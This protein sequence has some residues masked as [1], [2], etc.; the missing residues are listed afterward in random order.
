MGFFRNTRR[1]AKK[2]QNKRTG[3]NT[4]VLESLEPRILLDAVTAH[5]VGGSGDWSDPTHWDIGYVPNDGGGN[6]YIAVITDNSTNVVVDVTNNIK[7]SGLQNCE[8][9]K[10]N[11]GGALTASGTVI[12]TGDIG[13][14]GGTLTLSGATVTNTGHAIN[15]NTGTVQINNTT[16]NGG[17]VQCN[18]EGVATIGGVSTLSGITLNSD[19]TITDGNSLI[20]TGGLILNN[21]LTLLGTSSYSHLYLQDTQTISGTGQIVFDGSGQ[22]AIV[23]Q[24][25]TTTVGHDILVQDLYGGKIYGTENMQTTFVNEGK[26]S[27]ATGAILQIDTISLIIEAEGKISADHGSTVFILDAS[28]TIQDNGDMIAEY[29]STISVYNSTCNIQNSG[30]MLS[31]YGCEFSASSSSFIINGELSVRFGSTLFISDSS[32]DIKNGVIEAG[33]SSILS[34]SDSIFTFEDQGL[35]WVEYGSAFSISNSLFTIEDEGLI[36][37]ESDSVFSISDSTFKIHDDGYIWVES[38]SAFSISNSSFT[39]QAHD[40]FIWVESD[41]TFSILNSSFKFQDWGWMWVESGSTLSLFNSSIIVQDDCEVFIMDENW[42][43]VESGPTLSLSNSSFILKDRGHLFID[44]IDIGDYSDPIGLSTF[45]TGPASIVYLKGNILGSTRNADQYA[46]LGTVY[47]EGSGT[48]ASPQL[49]EVMGQDLGAETA[50][51]THNFVF[52]TL[53]LKQNTYV[54]LVD[55]SNNARGIGN[56]ALYVDSLVVPSGTTLDLNGLH[57]YVRVAQVSGTIV[58]AMSQIADGGPLTLGTTT[59]GAISVAGDLDEWTFYGRAGHSITT[60]V[61]TASLS[62]NLAYAQIDLVDASDNIVASANSNTDNQMVG[63]YDVTLPTDGTYRIRISAPET[64]IS[65]TGAYTVTAWDVT[66]DVAS[67]SLNQQHI[68]TIETPYSVDRW[69]FSA[70]T[71]D[72]LA[73]DFINASSSYI[74]FDL[75]GPNGWIGFNDIARDS[76]LINLPASGTYILTVHSVDGMSNIDYAFRLIESTQTDLTPNSTYSGTFAGSGQTQLFKVTIPETIPMRVVLDDSSSLDYNQVYVRYGSPPTLADYDFRGDALASADQDVLVPLAKPGTWYILVYGDNVPTESNYDLTVKT[77]HL[78]VTGIT[79][80]KGISNYLNTITLMGAGFNIPTD[81][82][83]VAIDGTVYALSSVT[84]DSFTTLTVTFD[85]D[86]VPIG[87]YSVRASQADGDVVQLD[88]TFSMV[89]GQ[90]HLETN[91]IVPGTLGR[92]ATAT[93]YIEYANTGDAPM[94]APLLVLASA[95][96]ADKPILTLDSSNLI[97]NLWTSAIPEGCSTSIQI[98]ASGKTPGVLQPGE[99]VRVPVYYSGLLLPWTWN[100]T[101]PFNLGVL[102]ADDTTPVD[103]STLK[104]SMKPSSMTTDAWNALFAGFTTD[105]GSTW[106]DYIKMLDDNA[107][108]LGQLGESVNDISQLLSFEFLQADGIGPVQTLAGAVDAAVDAPGMPIVFSRFFDNSVS[109]KYDLGRLGYGWDDNWNYFLSVRSDGTVDIMGPGGSMRIFQPDGR[110]S[111]RYF[112][113]AGDY[114]TLSPINGGGYTLK[115]TD[116]TVYA[117]GS[118]GTLNH[119]EDTNHNRI[120]C[121]YAGSLLTTLTHS[122]GQSLSIVYDAGRI[123]NM[124]DSVDRMTTYTYD[125]AGQLTSVQDYDGKI[126]SYTYNAGHSLTSVAAPGGTHGYFTYGTDGRLS[127]TSLDNGLLPTTFDYD[128]GKVI[129]TDGAGNSSSFYYDYRGLLL[130]TENALGSSVYSTYDNSYNLTSLTDATGRSS[131]YTYDA[132]GNVTKAVDA[133]GHSTLFTYTSTYNELA[134]LTDANGNKTT[135][136]YDGNGNL[137]S[138]AYADRTV[139]KNTYNSLGEATS[140]INRRGQT[141]SYTYETSGRI[142][143]ELFPDGTHNDYVYNAHGNLVTC[144]DPTGTTTFTYDPVTDYLTR[145]HYSG[146]KYLIFTYD[147]AGRRTSSTDELGHIQTYHYDIIGRLESVTDENTDQIAGY[148]YD[149]AGRLTRKDLGNGVYTA[150]DYDGAGQLLHLINCQPDGTV[151]S[152]FDYTYDSRGLMTSMATVDGSWAYTY[153]DIG[154]LTHAVFTS[155]NPLVQNQDLAYSYDAMGNRIQTVEN[156]VVTAY[157][158]NNMNQ[159]TQVGDITYFY[160]ADGNLIREVS[161]EGITTYTYNTQNQLIAITSP[162]GNWQ[163]NYNALGNRVSSTE[164]G[165]TTTYVTDPAGFGNVVNIYNTSGNPLT[166]YIYTDG[167]LSQITGAT[168]AYYTYGNVG[169]TSELTLDG[170]IVA[171]SYTYDP[172]GKVLSS[173]ATL[174]NP[175]QFVGQM[176]VMTDGG[177]LNYMRARY[178]DAE[179][180]RFMA[181][182]PIGIAGGANL[183]GYV[184][185][186]PTDGVDPVGLWGPSGHWDLTKCAAV[187]LF[188][189]AE[190]AAIASANVRTDPAYLLWSDSRHY[191]PGTKEDAEAHKRNQMN[192]AVELER[193]GLHVEALTA[194][195]VGLHTTQDYYAHYAQNATWSLWKGHGPADP[196]NPK[197][198]PEEYAQALKETAKYLNDFLERTGRNRQQGT[199]AVATAVDPNS[200]LGPAGYGADGHIIANTTLAYQINFENE[201]FATAPAQRVTITNQLDTDLGWNTFELTDIGFGDQLITV[202]EHTSHFETT[203]SMTYNNKTFDVMIEAGIDYA[204]GQVY[205]VFQSVDPTTS[206]PPDVLIGFLPPEDGTGRGMGHISY[207]IDP[208]AGL[209]TGTQIR[210]IAFI[211]FDGQPQI[212]TN[213]IN[214]HDPSQGTDPAKEAL[215]TIDASV[216]ESAVLALPSST[217]TTDFLVQWTGS[218]QGSGIAEYDVYVSTDGSSYTLWKATP[219]TSAIFTGVYG[220]TYS[221]YSV[222]KDNVGYVELAPTS[223][224]ATTTLL[225]PYTVPVV[226]AGVDLSTPEGIPATVIASFADAGPET[227]FS[228]LI[229][230]GD[231]I[232]SSGTLSVTP[233]TTG[234]SGNVTGTHLYQAPGSYSVLVRVTDQQGDSAT[235]TTNITVINLSPMV[236]AGTDQTVNEGQSVT[237]TGT[238]TDPGQLLGET[239]TAGWQ[240]YDSN[241][242]VVASGSSS[243][244]TFTP[245][246]GN[247]TAVFTVTDS[248]GASSSDIMIMTVL[249][250]VPTVEAGVDQTIN[251][252]Q[253]VTLTGIFTDPGQFLGETYTTS[254]LILDH[255]NQT[256]ASG[257]GTTFT[258]TPTAGTYTTIFTVTDSFGASSSDSAQIT[259]ISISHPVITSL[260]NSSTHVGDAREGQV[261]TLS[262]IFTDSVLGHTA[263]IDWGDGTM[264]SGT[265]TES[266]HT[267]SGTHTYSHGGIYTIGVVLS[268]GTAVSAASTV[269]YITGVGLHNG[270]LEVVGTSAT[271]IIGVTFL[272]NQITV[273]ACLSGIPTLHVYK[274]NAVQGITILAGDGNDLIYVDKSIHVP[275]LVDGGAGN[276]TIVWFS[277]VGVSSIDGG[278]G[279]NTLLASGT[280]TNDTLSVQNGT[281]TMNGTTTSITNLQ[282][283]F[284]ALGAGDDVM[285]V[286]NLSGVSTFNVDLGSGNDVFNG[287]TSNISFVVYG[288][289]G[290]DVIYGGSGN[291][292]LYGGSGNDYLYGGTG[293]DL[294]NGG[295][296][297]DILEGDAG[298]DTFVVTLGDTKVDYQQGADY[299]Q[300][301]FLLDTPNTALLNL[302]VR[303]TSN[304]N[305]AIRI[306]V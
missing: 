72:Q 60:L 234:V 97:Q 85:A 146:D 203:V 95:N 266:L 89:L 287:M 161:P 290:N 131:T 237:F 156:G 302:L 197:K 81:V 119:V 5:W 274:A 83:L 8:S 134:S 182:D 198:H 44:N 133:L 116:G 245:T 199:S 247:Y 187:G 65:A 9:I 47:F 300:N 170:G 147:A 225:S 144:T 163:Y 10:V 291:D 219:D 260:A 194:L 157:T 6:T 25:G 269:S 12:N 159:Y 231:G 90:P 206:L 87:I 262:G 99:S 41:S 98:L 100:S 277:E 142:T 233:V 184:G 135:Y 271:D 204:A 17:I 20:I 63:L 66:A 77:S 211:S 80:D 298:R 283:L 258:F 136:S 264:S 220:H 55:Q 117:F 74:A 64:Q 165:V 68:G 259:A 27:V 261:I 148:T 282:N 67:L 195:G 28:F 191:M 2:Y 92:H 267:L 169:S 1:L 132:K 242:N 45:A 172:F 19:T 240:V 11:T 75:T 304:P 226:D 185:N 86:T 4:V 91:L 252:G 210:N 235:D 70:N 56:E 162:Q 69:I 257:S 59:S 124:T 214:P 299:L 32:F 107:I 104:D 108:Y 46:L 158:T 168:T 48:A 227:S 123:R 249:N 61:N 24:R 13:T 212:A 239:Y 254:W 276:D 57:L 265:I 53:A 96:E 3:R 284:F 7:I 216:P 145:I 52:S 31:D 190:I 33:N 213:Q 153:D 151:L 51:F 166:H 37:V 154:E 196:D 84:I 218:D 222:A 178:Y 164:N 88:N 174:P 246:V 186:E 42:Q 29:D 177:G 105:V 22:N 114:G 279:T 275:A 143:S 189:P 205:A 295:T 200:L 179:T 255:N 50:G 115:E 122:S 129:V 21:N 109:E 296:G 292:S 273:F 223:P 128:E 118:N 23:L 215:N 201:S 176:G 294:L 289:G 268:S 78:I 49:L 126:T 111:G 110:Y 288:E 38:G 73:F 221:F 127:G 256:V 229:D 160:D 181:Q 40:G 34:I 43:H 238:F 112:S 138:T 82:S 101:V 270:M 30:S 102:T 26:I 71:N 180:G 62:P 18:G 236:D 103:W 253:T 79:P 230:W 209:P 263:V 297:R 152:C 202:P 281:L 280:A 155:T 54:K 173:S 286:G 149:N 293:D 16:I 244:F 141:V 208:K 250:V 130:K 303:L 243:T 251:E 175:F 140:W 248:F 217:N 94:A 241:N 207:I 150:Y 36:W 278:T 272:D 285:T 167:L 193:Q 121:G 35:I 58:G 39:I 15:A 183:Y 76:G 192:Q 171:N 228:T 139:E 224:D 137:V 93:L 14:A 120:T 113:Q 305:L 125:A 232:T 306:E 301:G 106:G 188:E